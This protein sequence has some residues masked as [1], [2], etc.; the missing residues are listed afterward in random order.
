MD[1]ID[2]TVSIVIL[3]WFRGG[4]NRKRRLLIGWLILKYLKGD[5]HQQHH[6]LHHQQQVRWP[7][8][9]RAALP[10]VA[11]CAG[12]RVLP[13][14]LHTCIIVYLKVLYTIKYNNINNTHPN[15][16][17]QRLLHCHRH[18]GGC[19]CLYSWRHSFTY[20]L[21]GTFLRWPSHFFFLFFFVTVT[22]FFFFGR[23]V[24]A[25]ALSCGPFLLLLLFLLLL[26]PW[27]SFFVLPVRSSCDSPV[28]TVILY[29]YYSIFYE[30]YIL[31][32]NIYM[33][34]KY[35]FYKSILGSIL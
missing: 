33:L 6:L 29:I 24:S 3:G 31:F 1:M 30:K 26:Y 7:Q 34:Q 2:Q 27:L 20:F 4:K 16:M 13:P 32:K 18:R 12:K 23:Y 5:Q 17:E 25:L 28:L 22:F 14:S 10:N 35:T 9:P 11:T 8:P 15:P 19:C 21:E